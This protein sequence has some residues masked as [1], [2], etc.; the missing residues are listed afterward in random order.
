MTESTKFLVCNISP[1]LI[2]NSLLGHTNS[3]KNVKHPCFLQTS[4]NHLYLFLQFFNL[5]KS[6]IL[7]VLRGQ[8]LY[9]PQQYL[10]F[11][12]ELPF[13]TIICPLSK[14]WEL[15]W[16]DTRGCL[17]TKVPF[18]KGELTG[19]VH[20]LFCMHAD[21]FTY[22]KRSSSILLKSWSLRQKYDNFLLY[23]NTQV[24]AVGNQITKKLQALHIN[25]N[26]LLQTL[27]LRVCCT[28]KFYTS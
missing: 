24:Y 10:T 8:I 12:L 9:L 25:F 26:G 23:T 4:L 7:E 3:S 2:L 17:H 5:S 11:K 13:T 27:V 22:G 14:I 19:T 6:P 16:L 15:D 1:L 28:P 21:F 20:I 18:I